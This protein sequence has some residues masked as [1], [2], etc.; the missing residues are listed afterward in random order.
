[1]ILLLQSQLSIWRQSGV[2]RSLCFI[3]RARL[4]LITHSLLYY[5]LQCTICNQKHDNILTHIPATIY[6]QLEAC[7]TINSITTCD[8]SVVKIVFYF[9]TRCSP[10]LSHKQLLTVLRSLHMLEKST[11]K[12]E[13][14]FNLLVHC[15][16]IAMMI[17]GESVSVSIFLLLLIRFLVCDNGK[18]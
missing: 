4:T 1:M 8:I 6:W 7:F 9:M 15:I 2:R 3:L 16:V 10:E 12:N 13:Q 17:K 14:Q 18:K 11:R 5:L